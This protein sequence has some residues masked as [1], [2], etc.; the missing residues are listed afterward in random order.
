MLETAGKKFRI[1]K[2]GG[3]TSKHNLLHNAGRKEGRKGG[4]AHLVPYYPFNVLSK[5]A[6]FTNGSLPCVWFFF[7]L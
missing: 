2:N 7:H 4:D 6:V 5:H 3:F 1:N